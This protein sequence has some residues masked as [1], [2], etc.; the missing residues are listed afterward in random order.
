MAIFGRRWAHLWCWTPRRGAALYTIPADPAY[1]AATYEVLADLWWRHVT[2]A[3]LAAAEAGM[4][5]DGSGARGGSGG[6]VAPPSRALAAV[7]EGFRPPDAHPLTAELEAA[8]RAMAARAATG[9]VWL[10]NVGGP[11]DVSE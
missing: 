6:G 3:R 11:V 8:S 10:E 4:V 2:P 1:W 5:V 7:L 9:A